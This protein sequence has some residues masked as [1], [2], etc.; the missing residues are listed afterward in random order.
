[1]D[2]LVDEEPVIRRHLFRQLT[3]YQHY[4]L[5][6]T[7]LRRTLFELLHQHLVVSANVKFWR[8]VAFGDDVKQK[9]EDR[10]LAASWSDRAVYSVSQL[11]RQEDPGNVKVLEVL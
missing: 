3:W 1:M 11:Q 6:A 2:E 9:Q 5:L 7:K 8:I 4:G 10:G